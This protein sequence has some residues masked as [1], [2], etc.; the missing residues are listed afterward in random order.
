MAMKCVMDM[1]RVA[2]TTVTN[3]VLTGGEG[4]VRGVLVLSVVSVLNTRLLLLPTR[5]RDRLRFSQGRLHIASCFGSVH[6]HLF[7]GIHALIRNPEQ[8]D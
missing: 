5:N 6:G 8:L 2:A 1:A 7:R 4:G 3:D